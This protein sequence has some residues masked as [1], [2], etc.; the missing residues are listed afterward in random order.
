MGDEG[1]QVL[2]LLDQGTAVIP[3][4]GVQHRLVGVGGHHAGLEG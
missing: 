2:A 3:I 4:P 1:G